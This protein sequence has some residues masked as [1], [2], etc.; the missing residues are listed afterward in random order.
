MFGKSTSEA[1]QGFGA[2]PSGGLFGGNQNMFQGVQNPPAFK[3][4]NEDE[5]D[6]YKD[7]DEDE[8]V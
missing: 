4:D 8:P 3:D 5:N 2:V 6:M 7:D 1:P